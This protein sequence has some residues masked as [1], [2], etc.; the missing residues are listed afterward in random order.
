ML[1]R[2]ISSA[3]VMLIAIRKSSS[4]VGNGT[5]IIRMMATTPT[6]TASWL[7]R[8][9]FTTPSAHNGDKITGLLLLVC[10]PVR[11]P[12]PVAVLANGHIGILRADL[13]GVRSFRAAQ[14]PV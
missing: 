7:M 12:R 6:G 1:T 2:T 13:S 4:A 3:P 11:G 5:T 14:A 8:F 10:G 9:G